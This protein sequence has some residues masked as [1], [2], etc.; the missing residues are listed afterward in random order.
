[1][2]RLLIA[3]KGWTGVGQNIRDNGWS[4]LGFDV[5]WSSFFSMRIGGDWTHSELLTGRNLKKFL[6]FAP[7]LQLRFLLPFRISDTTEQECSSNR[8]AK[9]L[10]K[11]LA[12]FDILKCSIRDIIGIL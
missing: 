11:R 1:M 3:G 2:Q 6:K 10:R 9:P 5:I 4:P 12:I 8:K 7:T